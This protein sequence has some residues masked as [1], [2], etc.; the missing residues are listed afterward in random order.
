MQNSKNKGT[1]QSKDENSYKNILKGTSVFGGVQVF[2]ILL[3]LIRGKFVALFLG[4]EGMGISSLFNA[5]QNTI[6]KASSLGLNLAVV[7]EVA[8]A[9]DN[10]T[11][12]ARLISVTINLLRITG[13]LG[14]VICVLLSGWLS[15]ITFDSPDYAWQFILLAVAVYFT[16]VGTGR[17]SILQ[18]LHEVK[19]ISI[20]SLVGGLTGLFAGVPL[21]Y[22][23]GTKGIVPAMAILA[24]STY[25]FYYWNTRRLGTAKTIKFSDGKQIARRLIGLGVVLLAGDLIGTLCTYLI[26]IYL[27]FEGGE[28]SV[29]LYQAAN[30]V[31]GQYSAAIFAAL[32]MDF[33]PRLSKVVSDNSRMTDVVNRQNEIVILAM[34]PLASLLILSAPLLIKLLLSSEFMPIVDLMRWMGL[35]LLFRAMMLPMGYITFAKGNKKVFFLMEGLFCNLLLLAE[36][37][38]FFHFFELKGLGYAVI[39]DNLICFV[40]YYL[41]NKRLYNYCFSKV[42]VR[43]FIVGVFLCGA[44]FAASFIPSTLISY[45]AMAVIFALSAAYSYIN[46]RQ[47]L[48][49]DKK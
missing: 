25:A 14:A 41:V 47:R 36:C 10:P 4:P 17:L 19:K 44:C 46:L 6:V 31:S 24:F 26:N 38:L 34:A 12:F 5:S 33:F 49:S 3:N 30:S 28:I 43:E 2:L 27:R 35:G 32:T 9:K 42:V 20:A 13:L 18:G 39:T 21:Y 37:I 22:F 45:T 48:I 40:L 8:Q 7:K 15:R 16:I 29:G 1:E 11:A 23:Y